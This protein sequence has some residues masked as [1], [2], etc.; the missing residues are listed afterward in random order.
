MDPHCFW[1]DKPEIYPESSSLLLSACNWLDAQ[2]EGR[3]QFYSA[4]EQP[5]AVQPAP[6][7]SSQKAKQKNAPGGASPPKRVTT[8]SL[9]EQIGEL[10]KTLPAISTQLA[11]MQERQEKVEN[12]LKSGQVSPAPVCQRTARQ[13]FQATTEKAA[14][15]LKYMVWRPPLSMTFY[16]R[17]HGR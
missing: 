10:S 5:P 16:F 17:Q 8:V 14:S 1:E 6:A 4:E 2:K 9:A 3:I 7:R 12:L 15:A 13:P 11:A